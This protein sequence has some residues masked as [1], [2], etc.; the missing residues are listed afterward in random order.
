MSISFFIYNF[1]FWVWLDLA[2]D[3]KLSENINKKISENINK[4]ISRFRGGMLVNVVSGS[5]FSS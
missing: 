5:R 1:F 4:K 2:E 3:P